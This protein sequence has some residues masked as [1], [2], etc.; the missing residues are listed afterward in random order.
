MCGIAGCL[1]RD[2]TAA[3]RSAEAIRRMQNRGY[4]SCGI[5][6]VDNQVIEIKREVSDGQCQSA[7]DRLCLKALNIRS[8]LSVAHTRWATHGKI[9]LENTHPHFSSDQSVCLVHNGIIENYDSIRTLLVSHSYEFYGSTDS[10]IL[11]KYIH[12]AL[13]QGQTLRQ[14]QLSLEGSW[15]VLFVWDVHPDRIYYLKSGSPMIIG[16]GADGS[17]QIVS[18]LIGFDADI[19]TYHLVKDGDYGYISL[20]E[21]IQSE[22]LYETPLVLDKI[23]EAQSPSPFDHWTLREISEQPEAIARCLSG[24]ICGEQV[25][26][27]ELDNEIGIELAQAEHLI[28]LACGTSYHAAKIGVSLMMEMR[29]GLS[30]DVI[31]GADFEEQMIPEGRRVFVII[32]SQSGETKDLIRGLEIANTNQ[33]KSIGLINVELSTLSR[34]VSIPLYLKAQRENAVAST[35]CFTNQCVLLLILALWIGRKRPR[36]S[37]TRL[38]SSLQTLESKLFSS[39]QTLE[40]DCRRMIEESAYQISKL[41]DLLV[42]K[43]SIFLLGKGLSEMIAREGALKI[44]EI[45]YIHAEGYASTSLKHGPFA[46]LTDG[47]PVILIIPNDSYRSKNDNILQEVQSRFATVIQI[48]NI[49]QRDENELIAYY[50]IESPLFSILSVIPLQLLA[51]EISVRKGLNP[52]FPRNL[53]KVVTVE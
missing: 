47:V 29:L 9:C 44:K 3:R 40:S 10:E 17:I 48:T 5:A 34:L 16:F 13:G 42:D 20:S 15:T 8:G 25:I 43:T 24:R 36:V 12:Y 30:Y 4:D 19:Q 21:G 46:L 18:E 7:I 27:T 52:D 6:Y 39:L 11:C 2:Q 22:V 35:K 31:D 49:R 23:T 1:S 45:T 28:F 33:I 37:E 14:I 41:A 53:A 38:L 51:Y 50:D 26:L 32:L